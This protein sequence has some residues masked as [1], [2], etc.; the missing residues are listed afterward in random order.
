M[1]QIKIKNTKK[2]ITRIITLLA[3]IIVLFSVIYIINENSKKIN[4]IIKTRLII[5]NED[6]T[7]NLEK[8][9]YLT[10][11][12]TVYL[13]V[14]DIKT[15]YD[16]NILLDED[17]KEIITT[18]KTKVAVI[19]FDVNTI[20]INGTQVGK[21]T[22]IINDSENYYLPITDLKSVYNIEIN[23]FEKNNIVTIDSLDEKMIKGYTNK[24]TSVKKEPKFFSKTITKIKKDE[25]IVI[26]EKFNNGWVEIRSSDGII[27][28]IK[29]KTIKDEK[30]IRQKLDLL[31]ANLKEENKKTIDVSEIKIS[32]IE[33]YNLREKYI[34]E[35]ILDIIQ[36]DYNVL[37][38]DFKNIKEYNKYLDR[39]II[40]L[41][42]RLLEYGINFEILNKE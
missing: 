2:A 41:K 12:N 37:C 22:G 30:E 5:N 40:E 36:K 35:I 4:N 3:I 21:I 23:V 18:Y 7:I 26:I 17:N 27:G 8:P 24:K 6:Y 39:F 19:N 15:I 1:K 28:Y 29:Q 31:L 32:Q 38:I 20:R 16:E 14:N 42:P 25:Q 33:N 34:E 10:S 11:N 13:S 9:I